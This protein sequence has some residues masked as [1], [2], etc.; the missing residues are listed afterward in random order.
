MV[1]RLLKDIAK[2]INER[3]FLSNMVN[4][5]TNCSSHEQFAVCFGWVGK[6][7]ESHEYFVAIYKVDNINSDILVSAMQDL[8]IKLNIPLSNARGQC[9]DGAKNMCSLRNCVSTQILSKFRK[10]FFMHCF[11]HALN[12]ALGNIVKSIRFLRDTTDTTYEI[13]NLVKK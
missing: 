7:Y 3:V 5:V 8:L 12:L 11:E 1:F 2:N 13:P 9:Y 10:A 6:H 4:E